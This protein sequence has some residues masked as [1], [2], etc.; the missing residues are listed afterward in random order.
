[1][2]EQKKKGRAFSDLD[3]NTFQRKEYPYLCLKIYRM[4]VN[5]PPPTLR[6]EVEASS[7]LCVLAEQ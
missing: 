6:L 3:Q 7:D 4:V 5:Y 1:M 2:L